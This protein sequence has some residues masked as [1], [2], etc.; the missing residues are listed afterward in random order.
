MQKE[1]PPGHASLVRRDDVPDWAVL[2][3]PDLAHDARDP[4]RRAR[5]LANLGGVEECFFLLIGAEKIRGQQETD[6]E[7]T[8]EDGK[9]SS[10]Q[11]AHFHLTESQRRA[12]ADPAAAAYAGVEHPAYAHLARLSPEARMELAKDFG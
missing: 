5:E 2:D 8:R 11:F 10:V 4:D 7:R 1:H 9:A 6:I 12:F 3:P